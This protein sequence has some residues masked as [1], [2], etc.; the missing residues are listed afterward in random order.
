MRTKQKSSSVTPDNDEVAAGLTRGVLRLA[1][2]LRAERPADSPGANA[3][4]VLGH[5]WHH[6]PSSPGDIAIAER[7]QPQSLT[8]VLADMERRGHIERAP[9]PLDRRK[10]LLSLTPTGVRALQHDL[11]GRSAWLE[12]ALTRLSDLEYQA[13]RMS[14]PILERLAQL[15]ETD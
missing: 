1:R 5:L 11:A 6:G 13:V 7:H 2:R 12:K 15:D 3:F 14:V 8:R 9:S 10:V 4:G